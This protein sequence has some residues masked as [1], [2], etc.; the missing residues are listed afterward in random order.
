MEKVLVVLGKG[1]YMFLNPSQVLL[2]PAV[3]GSMWN[4]GMLLRKFQLQFI[5]F[6]CSIYLLVSKNSRT[7]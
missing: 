3:D 2:L 4:E 7:N 1:A 6:T 5:N